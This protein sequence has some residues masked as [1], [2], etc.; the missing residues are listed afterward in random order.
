MK[1]FYWL[2]KREFWEHRGGFLWAPVITG[3]VFL[4]LNIM[5]IIA[6]EVVS[7]RHGIQ[8]G[9]NDIGMMMRHADAGDLAQVGAAAD[10]AMLSSMGM[11]GIVMGIVV[12]FYCLGSLYDDR[13]DRS[14]LFWKSLPVSNTSTVLS[15]VASAAVIAPVIAVVVSVICGLLQLVLFAI[16][17][18]FHGVNVWQ[19]L[20]LSHPLRA[21]ASLVSNVPLYALWALPAIGWLM[22]CSAGARN[23]PF[24]WAVVVPVVL[25]L[26]VSWFGI[27]GLFNLPTAWFWGNVV[28]RVLLSV[29]PGT[30]LVFD[31]HG[32]SDMSDMDGNNPLSVLSPSHTY[33]LLASPNL[34]IGVAAGAVLIA[35]AIWFRRVRDDS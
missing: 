27:M 18:S 15:K 16:V 10:V 4:V 21:I 29:F 35:G 25:G 34:W 6:A 31:K 7:A 8:I 13:R 5:A 30:A 2:L 23:K 9:G 3:A 32:L 33:G 22:L 14:V 17:L 11:I 26:L 24:L 20:T 28:Q 19:L 12:L 1:T